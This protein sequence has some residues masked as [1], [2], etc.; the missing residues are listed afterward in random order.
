M[1]GFIEDMELLLR[2]KKYVEGRLKALYN[3][4]DRFNRHG[5]DTTWIEEEIAYLERI[6]SNKNDK[7]D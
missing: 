3:T 6:L 5:K 4:M 2:C 7:E 1:S